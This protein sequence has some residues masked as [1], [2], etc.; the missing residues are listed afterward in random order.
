[1]WIEIFQTGKW[2]SA[3][4]KTKTYNTDDLDKIVS[5]FDPKN[6]IPATVGHPEK[7]T[8]PAYGWMKALK[9][10]GEK[11]LGD[12]EFVPE[13]LELLKKGIY[14]NRSI[15][16]KDGAINHVAFLG[17]VLPAVKGMEDISFSEDNEIETYESNETPSILEE[18]K[19]MENEELK[20][21]L[22]EAKAE[23]E[24]AKANFAEATASA[25]NLKKQLE[26]VAAEKAKAEEQARTSEL[27]NFAESLVSSGKITPVSKEKL[28]K[29]F[30]RIAGNADNF[31]EG[32]LVADL[33]DALESLPENETLKAEYAC[34]ANA[35]KY[36]E[37]KTS[38]DYDGMAVDEGGAEILARAK[39]L[40]AADSKLKYAD[41]VKKATAE[42]KLMK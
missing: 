8:A 23:L 14:K 1:M 21:Q 30:S 34:N 33:K 38:K 13:F 17:G 42:M 4:G 24:K 19:N 32:G 25:E 15:G 11:L 5:K 7:D 12:F 35:K 9:R 6:Q 37:C 22:E 2:T 28:V 40:M 20:K 18:T 16:L 41:A 29:V 31:S 26:E 27:N 10:E 39:E 3:Q 36:A